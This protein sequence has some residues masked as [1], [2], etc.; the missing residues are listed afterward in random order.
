MKKIWGF[1]FLSLFICSFSWAV[2]ELP[3]VISSNMVLQRDLPVPIWGWGEPGEKVSVSFAG[4]NKNTTTSEKG[5]WMVKLDKL[6]ASFI[7]STLVVKGTNEIKLQNILVGEV[8]ICSG[9]S[10][11]EWSVKQ[12]LNA[13]EGNRCGQLIP[14]SACLMYRG[15]PCTRFPQR[16]GR[17]EWA[18]SALL[19]RFPVLV[20]WGMP[21]A[22]EFSNR[23]MYLWD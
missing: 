1:S 13:Q 20:R 19:N 22:A 6:S 10:N 4:Q 3:S 2:I 21:S 7:P 16:K 5:E 14:I 11:M 23:S 15:T 17:G 8:W 18:R 9:Q 12:S